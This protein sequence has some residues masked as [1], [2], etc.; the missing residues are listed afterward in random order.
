MPTPAL[1]APADRSLFRGYRFPPEVIAH[2][3]LVWDTKHERQMRSE[4]DDEWTL[5]SFG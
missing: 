1:A 4:R 3:E 2:A 5:Y